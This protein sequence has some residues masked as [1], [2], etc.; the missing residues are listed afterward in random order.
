MRVYGRLIPDT[1]LYVFEIAVNFR[2]IIVSEIVSTILW[3]ALCVAYA[4]VFVYSAH[5]CMDICYDS[6]HRLNT[7]DNV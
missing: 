6:C 1:E 2:Y 5:K 3:Y 7:R 4:C